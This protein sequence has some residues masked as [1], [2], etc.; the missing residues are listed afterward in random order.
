MFSLHSAA[1]VCMLCAHQLLCGGLHESACALSSPGETSLITAQ[2]KV[3]TQKHV[4]TWKNSF[5][6]SDPITC[7]IVWKTYISLSKQGWLCLIKTC[8]CT[9]FMWVICSHS[10]YG[11]FGLQMGHL[12]DA[13]TLQLTVIL[14]GPEA[15]CVN[16]ISLCLCVPARTVWDK[17]SHSRHTSVTTNQQT[18]TDR[19]DWMSGITKTM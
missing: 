16:M 14:Q 5:I 13:F 2:A 6:T 15:V 3:L 19:V 4:W 11:P 17:P 12:E 18:H 7:F 9:E 1:G 10:H 8:W